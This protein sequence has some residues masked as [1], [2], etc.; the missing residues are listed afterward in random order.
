[1]LTLAGNQKNHCL[2]VAALIHEIP[3]KRPSK[4]EQFYACRDEYQG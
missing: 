1:M 4:E 2:I 3:D